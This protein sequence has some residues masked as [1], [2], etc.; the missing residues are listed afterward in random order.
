LAIDPITG[1]RKRGRPTNAERAAAAAAE[2][3]GNVEW[4]DGDSIAGES[5]SDRRR[6]IGNADEQSQSGDNGNA[7]GESAGTGTESGSRSEQRAGPGPEPS[8]A[9]KAWAS[10]RQKTARVNVEKQ[11]ETPR[12]TKQAKAT[13]AASKASTDDPITAKHVEQWLVQGFSLVAMAKGA[14]YWAIQ[15]PQTEVRPWAQPAAELLNKLTGEHAQKLSEANAYVA[16]TLGMY[17]LVSSRMKQDMYYKRQR[18]L[19]RQR[20]DAAAA[21][22]AAEEYIRENTQTYSTAPQ[23]GHAPR[24]TIPG[25]GAGSVAPPPI[26]GN[27]EG[28]S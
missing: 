4:I 1:K 12:A 18:I 14:E 6:R 5:V 10:V 3:S 2:Q 13:V 8:G 23:N 21:A 17:F 9:A 26:F 27:P 15:N 7:A 16:V 24:S 22:D 19:E 25:T 20:I 28:L 11:P